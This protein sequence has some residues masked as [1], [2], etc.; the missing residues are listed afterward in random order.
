MKIEVALIELTGLGL[1][2]TF[3]ACRYFLR[4]EKIYV[5]I[6]DLATAT[7]LDRRGTEAKIEENFPLDIIFVNGLY[8]CDSFVDCNSKAFEDTCYSVTEV[9]NKIRSEGKE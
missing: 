9:L 2:P 5:S 7:G 8:D 3:V 1:E 6:Y 4:K